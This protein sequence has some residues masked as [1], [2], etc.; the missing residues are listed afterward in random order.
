MASSSMQVAFIGGGNMGRALAE[1]AIRQGVS[2]AGDVL[3]VDPDPQARERNEQLGCRVRAEADAEIA[4]AAVVVLAVKPQL[5]PAVMAALGPRLR[6]SQIVVSIMA[7]VALAQMQA[8][9]NHRAVVR[10]MPNT[11]A[12]VGMGMNVY[13]AD[14][15]VTERQLQPVVKL[16]QASGEV[17]AVTSEDAIDAAT[18][19]SASGPAYVFYVAEHW[20]RAAQALGFSEAEATKLVQQ[21]LLGSTTLWRT[22]GLPAGQLREQVTS[23]GGTTAAALASFEQAA[24]GAGIEAGVRAAYRRAKELAGA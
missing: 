22:A 6:P 20:M 23:K 2:R 19:V 1:A 13:F 10:V 17:L 16:L 24:V 7:G 21:T 15:A 8:A 9:L 18:A 11:P 5:A 4:Q 3:V 14:P 12:Q